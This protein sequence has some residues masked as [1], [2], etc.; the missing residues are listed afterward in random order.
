MQT[1]LRR[2][3]IIDDDPLFAGVLVNAF[4]ARNFEVYSACDSNSA[5]AAAT[6]MPIGYVVLDL[7]LGNESGLALIQPLLALNPDSRILMLTGFANTATAVASIKT[8]ACDYLIKPVSI[9]EI[10]ACLGLSSTNGSGV[11]VPLMREWSLQEIEWGH[12]L[13]TLRDCDGNVSAT[14]R[15]LKMHI[16]TLQR[17][18]AMKVRK[19]EMSYVLADMREKAQQQRREAN[20]AKAKEI[21]S[22]AEDAQR[23][24]KSG[25]L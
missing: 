12:I 23:N 1:I 3:L 15:K 6:A 18:I 11:V 16:R 9:D 7:K 2:V 4:R 21:A 5:I 17:K 8:G 14:A 13:R 19:S 10:M 24:L 20:C 22:G 25:C